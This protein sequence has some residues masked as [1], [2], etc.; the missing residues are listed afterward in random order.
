M[1][2][3]RIC[4]HAWKRLVAMTLVIAMLNT[5]VGPVSVQA[6]DIGETGVDDPQTVTLYTD[7]AN[8]NTGNTDGNE[9]PGEESGDAADTSGSA[10]DT[11]TKEQENVPAEQNVYDSGLIRIYN[12]EQLE[13]V[14]TGAQVY[15]G[16][17]SADTFGTGD[18]VTDENGSAVVYGNDAA[19]MLMN[20]I[21]LDSS[22]L[23]QLPAGFAG[24]FTGTGGNAGSPLY[25][26][27][28]DT[29]YIYN[30]YQLGTANDPEAL[31]TVMS[32]DMIAEEFGM[33]QIVFADEAEETQL[34]YTDAHNYVLTTDFTSEMP[35]LKAAEVLD[36]ENDGRK[37]QGQVI[38]T[39][40]DGTEYIL[41]GNEDQLRAIGTGKHVYSAVYQAYLGVGWHMD[42][43]N[44]EYIMLYGGD[45]DLTQEQNGNKTYD[46]QAIEEASSQ[47]SD[48][49]MNAHGRCGV[50]Q[51]TGEPDPN[52]DIENS[53]HTY[54]NDEN[55]IIFRNIDLLS[56]GENS[57]GED[58][59][60]EPL[61]FSG[62]MI[63][64][65][66]MAG[67]NA[68]TGTIDESKI[69]PVTISNITV[70]K[71]GEIDPEKGIQG[72]G[73][74][75][76]IGS[77]P[78]EDDNILGSKGTV[79]VTGLNLKNVDVSNT[80]V[81]VRKDHGLLDTLL[82]A[83]TGLL[84]PLLWILG[85][86]ISD[87]PEMLWNGL[88]G[89]DSMYAAGSFAGTVSGDVKVANCSVENAKVQN[90]AD[91]TGGFIG[92]IQGKTL[93]TLQ[94]QGVVIDAVKGILQAI[95]LLGLGNVVDV[96]LNGGLID[97]KKL[98]PVGY[99][100][101]TITDCR[102][103]N[104]NQETLGSAQ[105]SFNGGFA[106]RIEG[107]VLQN[108]TVTQNKNLTVTGNKFVG[109]FA[110]S[111]AN[112]EVKGLLTDI[113]IDIL[114]SIF[115]QSIVAGVS[116]SG[117]GTISVT[118][119]DKDPEHITDG[120]AAAYTGGFTGYIA[121]SYVIECRIT[122]L[123]EVNSPGSYVGGFAGYTSP[124]A[125]LSVGKEY[126][127]EERSALLTAVLEFLKKVLGGESAEYTPLLSLVG[128]SPAYIYG[129]EAS[130]LTG[131]EITGKD[132]V[133]GVCRKS[134][135]REIWR[136]K[137]RRPL[138]ARSD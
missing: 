14:G 18:A 42:T 2:L 136:I 64:S 67:I 94:G 52:L 121:S 10:G 47:L 32:N 17:D 9:E 50:N 20:E 39:A 75:G 95:P 92:D 51:K 125:S 108:I 21:S 8:G 105:T 77:L 137:S 127:G 66:N 97:L 34:E 103:I 106:G 57:D 69:A 85:I 24:S 62:N 130:G 138:T 118:A 88:D 82:A 123:A 70:R 87:L 98:I 100:A 61:M 128:V 43:H 110:G 74:F 135:W 59:L 31:K 131:A 76:T 36:T 111:I 23:W 116:V 78:G 3:K 91:R 68:E 122:N 12:L 46:F 129:C 37:F 73:F 41:I 134:R 81:S 104:V 112:T 6:E 44:G 124:G 19:Y 4:K 22:D 5:S 90:E 48:H 115:S 35:E 65:V 132:Y 13:A 72:A 80:S 30:N 86:D 96:L 38:F 53:G 33:G 60:W 109:G 54:D 63:G 126:T 25:D 107:G 93:Y 119:T 120:N 29:I 56:T 102:L 79:S 89:N 133:G 58:N 16:D 28:T 11:E 114:N 113:D 55:Y 101:P 40:D 49:K 27:E 83:V 26:A 117:Q 1:R 7:D 99:A 15:S 84:T 71:E 45:A